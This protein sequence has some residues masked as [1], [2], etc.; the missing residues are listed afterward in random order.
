MADAAKKD[1]KKEKE[2]EKEKEK[3]PSVKKPKEAIPT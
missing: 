2:K 3:T 1:T